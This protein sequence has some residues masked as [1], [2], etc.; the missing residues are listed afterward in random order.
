MVT[1]CL[2][3]DGDFQMGFQDVAFLPSQASLYTIFLKNCGRGYILRT[4]ACLE[5]VVVLNKGML[6]VRYIYI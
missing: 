2:A 1:K 3:L 5:T 4:A 6:P